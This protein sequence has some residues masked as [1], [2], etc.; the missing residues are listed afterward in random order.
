MTQEQYDRWKDFALRMARTCFKRRRRPNTAWIVESVQ[1]FFGELDPLDI[2]CI[3]DWDNSDDY[4]FGHPRHAVTG[5]WFCRP[6]LHEKCPY[7][8]C[9]E[10]M[11]FR[12]AHPL[13]TC[14]VFSHWSDFLWDEFR[15][16]GARR[17]VDRIDAAYDRGDYDRGDDLRDE[18]VERWRSPVA[19][20]VRAGLDMASAPSA[21][22]MGFTAGDIRRMYPEG[23]PAWLFPPGERLYYWMSDKRNGTFAELSDTAAIAL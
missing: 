22:V 9:R 2:P 10:G 17:E 5:H 21:G 20:C 15:R 8:D 18:I 4:P 6:K 7:D 3:R 12:Y 11:H 13:P 16:Y 1:D 14:D 19:C 23:V